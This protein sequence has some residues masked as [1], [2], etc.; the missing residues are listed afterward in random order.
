MND[1]KKFFLEQI[2]S[3]LNRT[4][5]TSC[6]RWAEKYRVVNGG[7]FPGPWTFDHH[8]WLLEMHDCEDRKIIGQKA[9]QL[10]Y[11]EWA[12]NKSFYNIDIRALSVLYILPSDDDASDFSAD[13]F[14][15][16]LEAS[17]HIT[18]MFTSVRNVQHKRS[19]HA[20]LY[21][22]GSRSRSKLKSIDTALIIYD[23]VDEMKQEN[24]AL[25]EMRQSGIAED[26]IQ[27]IK[28]STPTTPETGI[29]VD[30]KSSTQNHYNFKCP[31]CSKLIELGFDNLVVT[32]EHKMDMGYLNSYIRCNECKVKIDHDNK[33]SILQAKAKGGSGRFVPSFSDR[34]FTGFYI[35]QLYSP[36]VSPPTLALNYLEGIED[37]SKA[38]EF[39][40]SR[41]GLPYLSE[42]AKLEEE[43]IKRLIRDYFKGPTDGRIITMG[44]DVGAVCHYSIE[45]WTLPEHRSPA[46]DVNDEATCRLIN[47][48]Q[49]S[50][51]ANDFNELAGLMNQYQVD[52]CIID[53]E[54]E[55]RAAYQFATRFWGR[56]LLCDFLWSA[57]GRQIVPGLEEDCVVKVNRT[58]WF[59]LA[60]GRFKNGTIILPKDVSRQYISHICSPQ[61]VYKKDRY[62]NNYG[63][64]ENTT[65]DH[66]ALSRVYNEIAL[67]HAPF[68]GAAT[69][70]FDS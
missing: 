52:F 15:R 18:N 35:N 57:Q 66:L 47:E 30:F 60:L 61:R 22:R 55:R 7:S 63:F 50:G 21:V 49:T 26:Q 9:A 14:G 59:D 20:S 43:Q 23:E 67:V 2:R 62:G 54:P 39:W 12:L 1:I 28:L 25:A 51:A 46:L 41:L 38:T 36:V 33:L 11:T 13:R 8:P 44:V 19:G 37:P 64:Y 4:T 17:E 42:G 31:S 10:G 34:N 32:A 58:S 3:K 45:E 68:H 48:G 27:Q 53:A 24:L 56:V 65:P 5:I 6:S 29:N 70:V 40:N 16:A 69:D